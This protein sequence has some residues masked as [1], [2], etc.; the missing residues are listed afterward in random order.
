MFLSQSERPSLAPKQYNWKSYS[1]VYFNLL[2]F[3][4]WDGKTKEVFVLNNTRNSLNLIF[5]LFYY[6]FHSNFHYEHQIYLCEFWGF[7]GGDIS[8]RSLP[9]ALDL[10]HIPVFMS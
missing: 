2:G 4:I 1:T 10:K 3:L 6:E 9:E 5:L 7:Q 8:G